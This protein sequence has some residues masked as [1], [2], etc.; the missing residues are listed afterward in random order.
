MP[1]KVGHTAM[2]SGRGACTRAQSGLRDERSHRGKFKRRSWMRQQP[3][4]GD[5]ADAAVAVIEPF[6]DPRIVGQPESILTM[7]VPDGVME[8]ADR[9]CRR[10]RLSVWPVAAHSPVD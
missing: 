4:F 9:P 7:P 3:S 5:C 2:E 1:P 8:W 6:Q 10:A